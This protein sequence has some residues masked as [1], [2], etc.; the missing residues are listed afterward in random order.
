MFIA[1]CDSALSNKGQ[2]AMESLWML[3]VWELQIDFSKQANLLLENPQIK[4]DQFYLDF[5]LLPSSNLLVLPID[6]THQRT[7]EPVGSLLKL[8][9]L[10]Y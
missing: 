9:F 3:L 6:W 5:T 1:K 7:S 10:Q 2:E 8:N 4:E